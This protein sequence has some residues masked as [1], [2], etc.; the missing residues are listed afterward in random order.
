MQ[1]TLIN[2]N[3]EN[4]SIYFD[5]YVKD[6]SSGL[7]L[8]GYNSNCFNLKSLH[9]KSCA[10]CCGCW[11]KTPGLCAFEDDSHEIRSKVIQSDWVIFMSPL[12]LGFT[13]GILK[14]MQDK[15]IPLV[16]PYIELVDNEC[17]HEKRYA[18]YPKIGLIYA[19]EKDTDEEDLQIV[20]KLYSRFALN[21]KSELRL[22]K[23]IDEPIEKLIHEINIH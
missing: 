8:Q 7:K 1:V 9:I 2:G 5:A 22:F 20:S 12:I 21:F 11:V 17:H 18:S 6:L 15:F 10:G 16:H 4:G 13:S 19:K 23:S 14:K 3:P